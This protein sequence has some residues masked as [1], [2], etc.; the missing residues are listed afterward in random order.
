MMNNTLSR[1]LSSETR[2]IPIKQT[3]A[4]D[5][6]DSTDGVAKE[7]KKY[8]RYVKGTL[9]PKFDVEIKRHK[10]VVKR[11][12]SNI[13]SINEINSA[14]KIKPIRHIKNLSV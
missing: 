9:F 14:Y 8:Y 1:F 7:F 5:I 6:D 11:I 10:E 4:D 12:N 3:A 2:P 13:D